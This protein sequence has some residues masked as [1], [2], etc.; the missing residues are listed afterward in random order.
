MCEKNAYYWIIRRDFRFEVQTV[1][2]ERLTISKKR[3]QQ[4][5]IT[6]TIPADYFVHRNGEE[7]REIHV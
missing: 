4:S 5:L 7:L 1:Q 2:G 6:V 3:S